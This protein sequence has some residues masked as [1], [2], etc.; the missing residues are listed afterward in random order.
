MFTNYLKIAIRSLLKHKGYSFINIL[1]LAIGLACTIVIL[2]FIQNE[3]SVD[4]YHEKGERIVQAYLT[5]SKDETT[6]HQ[7]TTSPYIG[8]MLKNEYPEVL[9]AVRMR[10]LQEVSFLANDKLVLEANGIAADANIFDLFTFQFIKGDPQTALVSPHSMILTESMAD[11][12]FSNTDALGQMI[13]IDDQYSF[14]VTGVIKDLPANSFRT[15]D[16]LVPLTFLEELGFD[17]VGRPYFPCAYLTFAL[18]QDNVSLEQLNA[19]VSE[20][21]RSE[22]QEVTF[23]TELIPL[24]DIYFFETGGTTRLTIMALVAMMI[25]ALAC[26]NFINLAT[27]R[28]MVRAKEIGIRKVT[29]ATRRLVAL[30]FMGESLFLS[31]IAAVVG[32]VLAFQFMPTFNSMTS[33]I[34]TIPL[35]NPIFMASLLALVFITGTLAGLYPSI[36]LSRVQP[37]SIMKKQSQR[38]GK[39]TFRKVLIVFQFVLSISFILSTLIISRQTSYLQN[40]NLGVNK[41]NLLY[42]RLE[43]DIR[44]RTPAVKNELLQHPNITHVSA[45]SDLP[46]TIRSGSYFQWGVRDEIDRRICTTF[47]SYD[48]LET[49]DIKLVD[50]R[51]FSQAFPNDAEESILVNEAALRKVGLEPVIGQPFYY[52]DRYYNLIGIVK[53]FHHNQLLSQAP[54]PL[55]FRLSPTNNDFLFVKIDA[56]IT[57]TALITSTVHDIQ[58]ICQSFSPGRPLRYQFYNDFSFQREQ[59]Q[60][61]I[62]K[63]FLI[64]TVLAI[65]IS[66][67]GLF[68]LASFMNQQKTKEVGIRK[69]L[70][71]SVPNIFAN[72]T[73]DITKWVL[74]ANIIAWPIAW[75]AMRAWL[76]NFAY[77]VDMSWWLFVVAGLAALVIAVLTVSFQAIKTAVAN[78]IKTLRYE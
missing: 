1:G 16:Y 72:L 35:S 77:R 21:M 46:T 63:L 61:I 50:G 44:E 7:S 34:T 56:N 9:D 28:H 39:A 59:L 53:D 4:K 5:A 62:R 55:A 41:D 23:D 60:N 26:V 49:F 32:L 10:G 58:T 6:N 45:G 27:A 74:I 24:H 52:A 65:F 11:K 76:Q 25:L 43:G 8:P 14:Q 47:T 64:S 2:A 18:L 22:G 20:R 57:D 73:R 67:L 31:L 69:V 71:A 12:Y 78:P 30:Q 40:F 54:E 17:I 51:F 36:F 42:I 48:Y 19:K 70:G 33:R 68:G 66:C 38:P 29:G 75:F 15:F 37:V 13:R 3:L